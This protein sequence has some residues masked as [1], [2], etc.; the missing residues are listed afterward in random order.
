[1]NPIPLTNIFNITNPNEFKLHVARAGTDGQPLQ[2][3]ARDPEEWRG[4]STWG[5]QGANA[6]NIY[7]RKYIF[8]LIDFHTE[9]DTWLFGGAFEVTD[10][11]WEEEQYRYDIK[12]L[13]EYSGYVGR[14]KI[15]MPKPARGRSF[16]L[17]KH[18]DKMVVSEILKETY[19]GAEFPGYDNIDH[20]FS[21]LQP[22]FENENA[23]WKVALENMQGVYVI[24]DTNNGKKY[25]GAAY[26]DCGIW[27]R[28]RAY[29][30][31]GH[32]GNAQLT[33]LINK[34][35]REYALKNFKLS[36]LESRTM[37]VEDQTIIDR[38]TYWKKVFLSREFGYNEN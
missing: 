18:L 10:T 30:K 13:D 23:D 4:W 3:Y 25:V 7:N 33:K 28:W 29:I 19:S 35:G 38:E 16:L 8:A 32:G 34:E 17:E 22:I 20:Q 36:L 5:E 21:E 31:S 2:V 12:D 26:G 15:K 11:R 24:T 6:K 14:L 27:E 37:R 1:M 9:V